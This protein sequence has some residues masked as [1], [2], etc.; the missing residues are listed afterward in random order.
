MSEV[1]NLDVLRAESQKVLFLGKEFEVGYIP[2]GA[3]IP[4]MEN[5]KKTMELKENQKEF[6]DSVVHLVSLFCSFTDKSFTE[7]FI[8]ENASD[9][10]VSGFFMLIAEAITNNF[11]YAMSKEDAEKTG[12][13]SSENE[14]KKTGAK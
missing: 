8:R 12:E 2:C 11:S 6:S 5:F 14:K 1:I 13:A 3:G 7:D 10:Q 4:I 9:R